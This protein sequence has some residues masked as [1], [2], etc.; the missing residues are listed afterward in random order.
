MT[1]GLPTSRQAAVERIERVDQPLALLGAEHRALGSLIA[2]LEDGLVAAA[3]D[4]EQ[5]EVGEL[6]DAGPRRKTRVVVRRDPA[7]G[8]AATPSG[9]GT[10]R[11]ARVLPRA[12]LGVV[13]LVRAARQAPSASSWSSSVGDHRQR[14][15]HG[16]DVGVAA[17]LR[18]AACGSRPASG[19]RSSG[20]NGRPMSAPGV[21]LFGGVFDAS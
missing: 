4:V 7:G 9:P 8:P 11:R 2:G 13:V 14:R 18:V 12:V 1:D 6:A 21:W 3:A 16:L 19:T 10:P 17:V 5:E 20:S 15:V